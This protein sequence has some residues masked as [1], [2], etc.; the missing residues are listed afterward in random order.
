MTFRFAGNR[1]ANPVTL[2]EEPLMTNVQGAVVKRTFL[3][4]L[5]VSVVVSAGLG[6][7]ALLAGN[8][9]WFEIR[10]LL[11]TV[12]ISAASICGLA[13]GAYWASGGKG[14]L[15]VGGIVLA[16]AA[17]GL[18][19]VGIWSEATSEAYWKLAAS[20]SVFSVAAGHLSLLSM[21]RL[22]KSFQWSLVAAYVT[23]LG[24]ALLIVVMILGEP[25]GEGMFRLLGVAAIFDAAISILVPVFHWL[26]RSQGGPT[27][28][29]GNADVQII[30]QEI[31]RLRAR[32]GELEQKRQRALSA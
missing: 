17:A 5:I 26:S 20:L 6:I 31:V 21:A 8:W 3:Y 13:C 29:A 19:I 7:V 14:P 25:R 15:P 16:I 1:V 22:A 10:I 27:A 4:A 11:T 23:I 30:D 32:I 9:G 28:P 24:V 2:P 12:T 18:V